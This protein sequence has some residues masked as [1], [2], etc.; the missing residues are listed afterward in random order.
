[1]RHTIVRWSI[2]SFLL[3]VALDLTAPSAAFAQT[4][5]SAATRRL[6]VEDVVRLALEQNLGIQIERFNPQ[7]RDFAIA[8]ARRRWVPEISSTLQGLHESVPI[9]NAFAGGIPGQ[10]NIV[11]N[12]VT[13]DVGITQTLPT[14]GSYSAAWTGARQTSTNFFN[15]FNPQLTSNLS[16]TFSQPLLRNFKIDSIRHDIESNRNDRDKSEIDLRAEI[17]RTTRDAKNAYWDL[18]YQIDNLRAQQDSLDL[19]RQA[20]SDNE[21]RVQ[22][23]TMASLDIVQAQAEVARNEEAVIVAESAIKEAEDR[24]RVMIFDPSMPD[25]WTIGLEP[26]E[27]AAFQPRDVDVDVAV[28][29]ALETRSDVQA[30]KNEVARHDLDAR[31]FHNQTLPDVS[32]HVSY[33][34]NGIGGGSLAPITSFPITSPNRTVLFDRGF[35]TV[36]ADV[37]SSAYPTWN[38][39]VTIARPLGTSASEASLA[40]ARLEAAQAAT[41]LKNTALKV[42]SEVRDAARQVQTNQKRVDS[43]RAFRELADRRLDAERRKF[44]AGM[45]T[46]FFVFQA[47]RDLAEARTDEARAMADYN[48]SLVDFEAVQEAPL[49]K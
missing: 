5:S 36:L 43:A 28:R 31:F 44:A 6:S 7:I 12:S 23:G 35:A 2:L 33:L 24:L 26:A 37:F 8:E 22:A 34:S 46:N 18:T 15:L 48:K 25:F 42:A 45:Q 30:E 39:G 27:M 29:R 21:K 19:S 11:T 10:N 9:N 20:L 41:R 17:V 1:M 14:G 16:V 32:A 47:Q 40:K 13:S 4:T 49:T 3:S 38:I